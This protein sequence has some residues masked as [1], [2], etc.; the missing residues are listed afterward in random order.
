[1]GE[2]GNSQFWFFQA[3][4]S[5]QAVDLRCGSSRVRDRKP[6][7]RTRSANGGVGVGRL[8]AVGGGRLKLQKTNVRIQADIRIRRRERWALRRA[9]PFIEDGMRG[10]DVCVLPD[11]NGMGHDISSAARVDGLLRDT[12]IISRACAKPYA[13]GLAHTTAVR[14]SCT[15]SSRLA[16]FLSTS[17]TAAAV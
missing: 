9:R 1:M 15:R 17:D 8:A 6:V 10:Y 5:A 2:Y 11:P 16:I 3:S 13:L 4:G 14:T 7:P 12:I